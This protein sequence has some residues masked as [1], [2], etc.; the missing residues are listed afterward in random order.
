M[1][2]RKILI[3]NSVKNV[4]KASNSQN[5]NSPSKTSLKPKT[6][7]LPRKQSKKLSRNMKKFIGNLT[8]E[9]FRKLKRITNFHF[10]SQKNRN[11]F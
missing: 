10:K 2:L 6:A 8:R 3:D 5:G 1:T 9:G 4:S 11:T 7:S